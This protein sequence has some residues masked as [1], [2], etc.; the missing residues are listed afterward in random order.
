MIIYMDENMP[1]HLAEGF[2]ILQLPEGLKTGR[3]IDVKY[4]PD[5]VGHGAKDVIWIPQVGSVKACVITQDINIQRR[6]HELELYRRHD[7]GMFFLRGSSKKQGMS[8]W[9]MVES[10]AK[11]WSGI[12][13]I[14]YEKKGPFAYQIT[15]NR[16]I[17]KL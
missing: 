11:N 5:E 14:V 2:Q 17:K 15:P 10:L 9:Q 13:Q 7:I 6:K 1:R 8:I 4:L 12:C 16:K 3:K